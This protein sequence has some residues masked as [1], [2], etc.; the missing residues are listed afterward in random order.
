M[1]GG[2]WR[3][4]SGGEVTEMQIQDLGNDIVTETE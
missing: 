1:G 3:E 2:G 4:E